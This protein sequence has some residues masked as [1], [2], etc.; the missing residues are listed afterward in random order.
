MSEKSVNGSSIKFRCSV[1][2]DSIS[3]CSFHGPS[4][5]IVNEGI[6]HNSEK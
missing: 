4:G 3:Q 1:D 5:I 2:F 6:A